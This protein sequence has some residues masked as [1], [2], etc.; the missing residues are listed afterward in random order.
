MTSDGVG[1][2]TASVALIFGLI[3]TALLAFAAAVAF[4]VVGNGDQAAGLAFLAIISLAALLGSFSVLAGTLGLYFT[5]RA[6]RRS[7][8]A[9]LIGIVAALAGFYLGVPLD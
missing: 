7:W 4:E 2:F 6:S 1:G 5:K 3:C 9:I 8:F